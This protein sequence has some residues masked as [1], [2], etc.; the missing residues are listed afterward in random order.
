MLR[1]VHCPQHRFCH[2]CSLYTS[3]AASGNDELRRRTEAELSITMPAGI[4]LTDEGFYNGVGDGSHDANGCNLMVPVPFELEL[5]RLGWD[6]VSLPSLLSRMPPTADAAAGSSRVG[7][8]KTLTTTHWTPAVAGIAAENTCDAAW[9]PK[10]A[11]KRGRRRQVAANSGP[12]GLG[13]RSA[14]RN[15]AS[16]TVGRSGSVQA[17]RCRQCAGK[18][19]VSPARRS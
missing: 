1:S 5:T 7:A 19:C 15:T 10:I 11:P 12:A 6:T 14:S 16:Q 18:K 8:T 9:L 13:A 17:T 2:R 4:S 3:P